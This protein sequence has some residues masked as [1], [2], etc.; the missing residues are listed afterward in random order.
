MAP[1]H[2]AA[3]RPGGPILLSSLGAKPA[4]LSLLRFGSYSLSTS[5]R[6][7]LIRSPELIQISRFPWLPKGSLCTPGMITVRAK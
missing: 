1:A 5:H 6:L 4:F 7:W 2:T 3:M